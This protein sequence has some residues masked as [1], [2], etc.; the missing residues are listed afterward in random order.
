MMRDHNKS[1]LHD[2]GPPR[3][4]LQYQEH[5]LGE[6]NFHLLG[7]IHLVSFLCKQFSGCF[8]SFKLGRVVSHSY[9]ATK[10]S[11]E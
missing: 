6:I 1:D 2:T 8:K 4:L 9:V 3:K 11:N 7:E 10:G 5:F